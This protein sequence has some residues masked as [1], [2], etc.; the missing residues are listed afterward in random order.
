VGC[1]SQCEKYRD[2]LAIHEA[3]REKQLRNKND[4]KEADAFLITH[5]QRVI[6]RKEKD[7]KRGYR[8]K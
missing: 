6:N 8:R 3:E 1:Q 7:R 5:K 4:G 2:W